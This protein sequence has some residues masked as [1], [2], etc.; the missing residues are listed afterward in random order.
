[1]GMLV[2]HELLATGLPHLGKLHAYYNTVVSPL[3]CREPAYRHVIVSA[4][5]RPIAEVEPVVDC[6]ALPGRRRT[7]AR[8]R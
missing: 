2:H 5:H 7:A 6:S 8:P 4:R 1:M 3:D